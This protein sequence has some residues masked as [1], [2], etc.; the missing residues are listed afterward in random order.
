MKI[1]TIAP[2]S[3]E[4]TTHWAPG[5]ILIQSL[6]SPCRK[7]EGIHHLLWGTIKLH[8]SSAPVCSGLLCS[9]H[10]SSPNS[11]IRASSA[12]FCFSISF[13]QSLNSSS[14]ASSKC[15][16]K[17]N[18][19][20]TKRCSTTRCWQRFANRMKVYSEN[21]SLPRTQQR[22]ALLFLTSGRSTNVYPRLSR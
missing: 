10:P 9:V 22:F 8:S 5:P 18:S 20:P 17:W 4:W 7:V 12:Q 19:S 2:V 21:S 13:G 11:P 16:T 6:Y 1:S 3:I 15:A 14:R